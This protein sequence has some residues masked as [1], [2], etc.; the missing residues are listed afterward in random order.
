M[1]GG[2]WGRA[3]VTLPPRQGFPE[4]S[5]LPWFTLF[6]PLVCLLTIRATRDLVDDIVSV[7]G[8]RGLGRAGVGE[9]QG[10]GRQ[11]PPMAPRG[12]WI[13]TTWHEPAGKAACVDGLLCGR[14]AW[15]AGRGRGL[16]GRGAAPLT[17]PLSAQGRHRSDRIINNRPCQILVGKR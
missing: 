14:L 10:G 7:A 3:G 15:V 16:A 13:A 11:S 17:H 5:T 2:G 4:I 1:L 8:G 12:L 9:G 6:A